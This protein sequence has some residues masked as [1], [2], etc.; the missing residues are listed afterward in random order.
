MITGEMVHQAMIR[1]DITYVPHHA[2]G[3][4]GYTVQYI[5]KGDRLYFDASCACGSERREPR[6]WDQAA[7]WINLQCNET[8]MRDIARRFG[9]KIFDDDI[10]E[11][12][13]TTG[14]FRR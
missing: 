11:R 4:C 2:C 12:L 7:A 5:R 13:T 10:A 6:S 9:V 8:N 3:G 1:E 14:G